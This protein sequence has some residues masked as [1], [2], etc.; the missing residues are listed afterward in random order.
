MDEE[1]KVSSVAQYLENGKTESEYW[2][3]V[4]IGK[5]ITQDT[6]D[7]LQEEKENKQKE[8]DSNNKNIIYYV[9]T[10]KDCNYLMQSK[11]E[12]PKKYLDEV[13]EDLAKTRC[14]KCGKTGF[15]LI[16]KEEY[17]KQEKINNEKLK[18]LKKEELD[19]NR[20]LKRADKAL[21]Y[22]ER[23]REKLFDDLSNKLKNG[24]I[25]PQRFISLFYNCNYVI[26]KN[27]QRN[28]KIP[29]FDWNEHRKTIMKMADEVVR[30]YDIKESE[31]EILAGY[32]RT[33]DEIFKVYEEN[34][35]EGN[36]EAFIEYKQAT[37][38]NDYM[39]FLEEKA[40]KKYVNRQENRSKI[41]QKKL[42]NEFELDLKKYVKNL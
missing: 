2:T 17:D 26:M 42:E 8:D 29:N 27:T 12:I 1:K 34:Y 32:D 14:P 28:Y 7:E 5:I 18:K 10:N 6:Y 11:E 22:M 41:K 9:C 38:L 30:L 39:K 23:E 19:H 4:V 33:Q 40:S 31:D 35:I 16:T 21:I 36:E 15:K 20:L 24:D 3:D 13:K 37:K 25:T